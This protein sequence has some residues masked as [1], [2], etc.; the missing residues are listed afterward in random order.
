MT[1][2]T[3]AAYAGCPKMFDQVRLGDRAEFA[4]KQITRELQGME[5]TSYKK[6]SEGYIVFWTTED[7][8]VSIMAFFGSENRLK[9]VSIA[10]KTNA[11]GLAELAGHAA[12]Q[13]KRAGVRMTGTSEDESESMVS[14]NFEC[15]E[16][17]YGI[18]IKELSAD[19]F[20]F[21]FSMY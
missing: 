12:E 3:T 20:I 14:W 17:R 16:T 9:Y 10:N 15:G 2:L 6:E 5:P 8:I 7:D 21:M 13:M 1:L 18:S 19:L 11:T 4:I